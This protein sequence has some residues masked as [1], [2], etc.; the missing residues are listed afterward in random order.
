MGCSENSPGAGQQSLGQVGP[1]NP[2]ATE[3]NAGVINA[4]PKGPKVLRT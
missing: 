4:A 1:T 2:S 3:C